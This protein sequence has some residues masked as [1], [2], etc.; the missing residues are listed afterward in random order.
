MWPISKGERAALGETHQVFLKRDDKYFPKKA[1]K[2]TKVSLAF[3]KEKSPSNREV[4]ITK[5]TYPFH[6]LLPGGR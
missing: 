3:G 4:F 5:E 6:I 2:I 1:Y